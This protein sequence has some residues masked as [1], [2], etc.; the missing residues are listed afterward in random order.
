M[1][2]PPLHRRRIS[3]QSVRG[4]RIRTRPDPSGNAV[5]LSELLKKIEP[6]LTWNGI[7]GIT[8][9]LIASEWELY[10]TEDGAR[11]E[12]APNND[13][14]KRVIEAMRDPA[15]ARIHPTARVV[16]EATAHQAEL[17]ADPVPP[18]DIQENSRRKAKLMRAIARRSGVDIAPIAAMALY[19]QVREGLRGVIPS[20]AKPF[21][22]D[23]VPRR[24]PGDSYRDIALNGLHTHISKSG[25]F[26]NATNLRVCAG[27]TAM[28]AFLGAKFASSP[29]RNTHFTGRASSRMERFQNI[30]DADF[31]DFGQ[32]QD[33]AGNYQ[34]DR[35]WKDLARTAYL[36]KWILPLTA[37][38]LET[39]KE[40][41][42]TEADV[43]TERMREAAHKV[44]TPI[45]LAADLGT[46]EIRSVDIPLTAWE[47]EL[48]EYWVLGLT[49]PTLERPKNPLHPKIK[50]MTRTQQKWAWDHA[51]EQGM[52]PRDGLMLNPLSHRWE[53]VGKVDL[54]MR[55]LAL[56][57]LKKQGL[58]RRFLELEKHLQE[59]GSGWTRQMKQYQ[60]VHDALKRAGVSSSQYEYARD[61]DNEAT[62]YGD[63]NMKI[64]ELEARVLHLWAVEMH[65]MEPDVQLER[66]AHQRFYDRLWSDLQRDGE[67]ELQEID[68]RSIQVDDL[69][70]HSI[71]MSHADR[72]APIDL[73]FG[74]DVGLDH[75]PIRAVAP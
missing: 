74:I 66:Q 41:G 14:F 27:W 3:S 56:V 28:T 49:E 46:A 1:P 22:S 29:F 36:A 11:G 63:R 32:Y 54:E 50:S 20:D 7:S 10:L 43:L 31:I 6:P 9:Y 67:P 58:D 53:S 17:L 45:R 70:P 8:G 59:I 12:I 2:N 4:R 18:R 65:D 34:F 64:S 42:E 57:E 35:Y 48:A 26:S 51:S 15:V 38:E 30:R 68:I 39:A 62:L 71:V 69:T 25:G 24:N 19:P 75:S 72:F 13:P 55:T 16:S 52:Y 73:D 37:A 23:T 5:E 33:E 61:A 47:A 40:A 21:Y 60:L 44:Y